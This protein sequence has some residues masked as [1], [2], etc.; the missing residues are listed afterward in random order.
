PNPLKSRNSR[1]SILRSN[2][3]PPDSELS[4][5]RTTISVAPAELAHYDLAINGVQSQLDRLSSE[6]RTLASYTDGCRSALSPI[7]RVPVEVLVEIFDLCL[8]EGMYHLSAATTPEAEGCSLWHYTAMGTP[9]LWSTIPIDTTLWSRCT[10]SA[11]T[12]F[13][14]LESSLN[15]GKDHSLTMNVGVLRS[16]SHAQSVLALLVKHA[17]RW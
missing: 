1:I 3:L 16:D 5:F 9:K 14:L 4:S 2:S 6:R 10:A 8:A 12:L 15:R 11:D 13:S 17:P 7:R